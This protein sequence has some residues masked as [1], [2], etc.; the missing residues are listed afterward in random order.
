MTLLFV[1]SLFLVS[2][3]VVLHFLNDFFAVGGF[4]TLS[5]VLFIVASLK[6]F[7]HG[8]CFSAGLLALAISSAYSSSYLWLIGGVFGLI[9]DA[10]IYDQLARD[11]ADTV[12]L[13][14]Q[15]NPL[16]MEY[17]YDLGNAYGDINQPGFYK[18]LGILYT[19]ADIF[20]ISSVSIQVP[21][22]VNIA[23]Y[24]IIGYF[25]YRLIENVAAPRQIVWVL[26]LAFILTP[27]FLEQLVWLRKDLFTL[28]VTL[29]A[30]DAIYRRSHF[31][32]VAF[33]IILLATLRLPQAA[34]V[35]VLYLIYE[36]R[37]RNLLLGRIFNVNGILLILMIFTLAFVAHA[38]L[39]EL[40]IAPESLAAL[41]YDLPYNIGATS[42]LLSNVFGVAIYAIIYP[43]PNLFPQDFTSMAHTFFAYL[44]LLFLAAVIYDLR[45][46]QHYAPFEYAVA[47]TFLC[48]LAG[49][50]ITAIMSWKYLG[51]V[52]IE[53]RYKLF[54]TVLL[55]ALV[56]RLLW[57]KTSMKRA[58]HL[59]CTRI[60]NPC[61]TSP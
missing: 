57:L 22:I 7:T 14:S 47:I 15:I 35:I 24:A 32:L 25:L 20:F 55:L 39:P 36:V 5:A 37:V 51:F 27:Y 3:S 18:I 9:S 49:F 48:S 43:P 53:P 12:P 50:T 45:N 41:L 59:L 33:Y 28:A 30:V 56:A 1:F 34:L 2:L 8:R 16:D 13:R 46:M 52:V 11:I 42:T 58:N 23:S 6:R 61:C 38:Y 60:P 44:H 54:T 31:F 10:E 21:L 19:F 4:L 17:V 40:E 29:L 26:W